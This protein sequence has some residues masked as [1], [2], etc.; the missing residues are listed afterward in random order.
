MHRYGLR[1]DVDGVG[2]IEKP[3]RR[4]DGVNVINNAAHDLD[5]TQRH[6]KT[7]RS[8]RLL[9]NHT[10]RERDAFIEVS[11]LETAGAVTGEHRIAIR[12]SRSATGGCGDL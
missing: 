12:Q 2:V 3:R 10:L 9:P 1:N 8:L 7:A 4:T 5:R 11:R 6:E